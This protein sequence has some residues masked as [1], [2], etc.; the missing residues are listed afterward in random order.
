MAQAVKSRQDRKFLRQLLRDTSSRE[1]EAE[2]TGNDHRQQ[3]YE[4]AL[5]SQPPEAVASKPSSG[6]DGELTSP[7]SARATIVVPA[8]IRGNLDVAKLSPVDDRNPSAGR[9][10]LGSGT[11]TA[12]EV[13]WD[14]LSN[15]AGVMVGKAA[16]T[17]AKVSVGIERP[18]GREDSIIAEWRQELDKEEHDEY[19]EILHGQ[20]CAGASVRGSIEKGLRLRAKDDGDVSLQ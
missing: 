19:E 7:S 4:K 12:G 1:D 20:G 3:G 2:G 16:D 18:I 15:V 10:V 17:D 8:E 11:E 6:R 14:N 9:E 5:D 13:V